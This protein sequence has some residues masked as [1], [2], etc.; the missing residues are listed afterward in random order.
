MGSNPIGAIFK[1][2]KLIIRNAKKADVNQIY[3]I[4]TSTGDFSVSKEIKFYK[5]YELIEWIKNKQNNIIIVA[6]T[7]SKI[8]GFVS[9]KIMSFH[10]A[11]VDN[12]LVLSKFRKNNIGS[13]IQTFLEKELKK[14]KISYLTGLVKPQ[15]RIIR[16]FLKKYG[17]K[18]QDK[19][20]WVDKFL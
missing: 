19:Y 4:G 3:K 12:F 5:K 9:C 15:K 17:F 6:E 13:Q 8:I 14:R 11:M 2:D 7:N 16:K 1:M 20:I 18:E 10:W